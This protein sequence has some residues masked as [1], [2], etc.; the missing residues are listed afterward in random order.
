MDKRCGDCCGKDIPEWVK[1]MLREQAEKL[2][3]RSPCGEDVNVDAEGD[4]PPES[5]FPNSGP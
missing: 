4:D 5:I 2:K 1:P 3:Q